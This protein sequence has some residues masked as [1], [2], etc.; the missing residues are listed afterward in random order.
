MWDDLDPSQYGEADRREVDPP[1]QVET[2]TWTKAGQL[3][4]WVKE[5]QEWRGRVRVRTAVS[6]GSGLLIFVPGVKYFAYQTRETGQQS[7]AISVG[8]AATLACG[9]INWY[10]NRELY[11]KRFQPSV[12]M[13]AGST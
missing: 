7:E 10:G 5:R 9:L 2:A 8:D 4:W 3:D 1:I 11:S 13:P 6:A 12:R